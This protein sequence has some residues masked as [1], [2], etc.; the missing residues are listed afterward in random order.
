MAP[1][2]SRFPV[3]VFLMLREPLPHHWHIPVDGLV[4]ACEEG[5]VLGTAE[6]WASMTSD[7]SDLSFGF[8]LRNWTEAGFSPAA[9]P[10]S[11]PSCSER[12]G[13]WDWGQVKPLSHLLGSLS[14]AGWL[15][16]TPVLGTLPRTNSLEILGDLDP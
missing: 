10:S 8:P 6:G 2:I 16:I 15:T 11:A 1:S 3:C 14:E 4:V 5:C 13:N 12:T 7:C 9:D